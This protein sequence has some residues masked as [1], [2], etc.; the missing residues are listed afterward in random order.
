MDRGRALLGLCLL[1]LAVLWP[2]L[3]PAVATAQEDDEAVV[4]AEDA[5]DDAGTGTFFACEA[6]DYR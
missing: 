3:A 6:D 5:F 1:A 4:L 2:A